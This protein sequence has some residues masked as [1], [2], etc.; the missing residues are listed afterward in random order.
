MNNFLTYITEDSEL[1]KEIIS[2]M[3]TKTKSNVKDVLEKINEIE[4]KYNDYNMNVKK[5]IEVKSRSIDI[6]DKNVSSKEEVDKLLNRIKELQEL[7]KILLPIN[8]YYEKLGFDN[9]L[10]EISNFADFDFPTVNDVISKFIKK[11]EIIGVNLTAADFDV[12]CYVNDYMSEFFIAYQSGDKKYINVEPIFERC[13]WVN[14]NI[15]NHIQLNFRKLIKKH[16]SKFKEKVVSIQ[17]DMKRKNNIH[18]YEECVKELRKIHYE[19]ML[20]NKE[21]ISDITDMA[22]KGEVD[23][24]D[25]FNTSKA[26]TTAMNTLVVDRES[27]KDM[28]K[29]DKLHAD[30]T[31]LKH[32]IREFKLYNEFTPFVEYSKSMLKE[33]KLEKSV[34]Q[35]E[36][37]I[38]DLEEELSTINAVIFKPA[39]EES[40]NVKKAF[41]FADKKID[42]SKPLKQL[43]AD[44]ITLCNKLLDLYKNVDSLYF[45]S[46]TKS[47][48]DEYVTL[49]D[50]LNLY[51]GYDYFKKK[52][53]KNTFNTENYDELMEYASKF[54]DF[55]SNPNNV[56]ISSVPVFNDYNVSKVIVDKYRMNNI[57]LTEDNLRLGNIDNLLEQVKLFLRV[58]HILECGLTVEKLWFII[59]AD[60]IRNT[61]KETN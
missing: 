10:Y 9:L 24:N 12:S 20:L 49:D 33:F 16:E 17:D 2:S 35:I 27:A 59:E 1:K 46:K 58:T 55:C 28:T 37:E 45:L 52:G 23:I 15:I 47:L 31:K 4:K 61:K 40:F 51:Y 8:T 7:R 21:S 34:E 30:L 18:S 29:K 22:I 44:S 60:K 42:T 32:I 43:Q 56:V 13:Y 5:Y 25:F 38:D 48:I 26:F 57:N 3:P 41:K 11:F 14:P 36:D 54:D 19:Y 50:F 39:E 6:A 53:L